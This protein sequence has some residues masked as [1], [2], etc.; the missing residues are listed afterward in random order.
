[1][2]LVFSD[3]GWGV[4]V[5]EAVSPGGSA[6]TAGSVVEGD[7]VTAIAL[8]YGPCL[9]PLLPAEQGGE[10]LDEVVEAVRGRADGVMHLEVV[11][12]PEGPAAIVAQ[13]A[14]TTSGAEERAW[15]DMADVVLAAEADAT[16]EAAAPD[17]DEED[18]DDE[19]GD[20]WA[21]LGGGRPWDAYDS[22][23]AF[24]AAEP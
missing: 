3:A 13:R 12:L 10:G 15:E 9:R 1:M 24:F 14:A 18:G 16:Y 22:P 8:P 2:G 5:V 4:V 20:A 6:A 21:A 17:A 19:L 11:T 7:V 23:E